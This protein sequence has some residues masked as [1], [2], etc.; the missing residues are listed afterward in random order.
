MRRVAT[1]GPVVMDPGLLLLRS[2]PRDD[3]GE[4]MLTCRAIA[5]V[6]LAAASAGIASPEI[7]VSG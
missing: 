4:Q 7:R 6:Q 5:C 1:V 2:R 3:G